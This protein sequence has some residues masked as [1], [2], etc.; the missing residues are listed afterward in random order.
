MDRTLKLLKDVTDAPGVPGYESEVRKVIR[1]Y[2]DGYAEI[3]YDR[4]G[5]II[6]KKTGTSDRPRIMIAGHMDEI[7]FMVTKITKE[8][9]IKFQTLGG[10][11][12]Q[13]MLAQ[14][15][16]IKTNKGD[17]PGIIGSKPP[18]ILSPEERNKVVDRDTMF[19][20]VGAADEK[21]ATEVFGIRPG[22]PIIP[23]S[24]FTIMKNEKYLMAKA[25]D[26]RL[27]CALFIEVI[28]A[29]QGVDHPNTVYGV[30]TVQ[31]EVGLRGAT[32][33]SHVIDPDIG[34]ALEV[35]I[36]GDTPGAE[37]ANE[38]LGQG[39][40]VLLYDA[41]M[42]PHVKLRDFVVDTA[43]QAGIPLQ[44]DHMAGGGT[45]AGRIH[46]N[47]RGVPSLCIAVPT[48]YI[49]SH[50]GIIHRDDYENAVKLV[51][52]L[53]KRLDEKTVNELNID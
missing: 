24:P 9:F 46:I 25:W 34:F 3:S 33:S 41:S 19:I 31:E 1:S 21:E 36:A 37:K 43:K 12:N 39:P 17:V 23:D 2:M 45:D 30:G 5:S 47:G 51:L 4:I 16:I 38:K 40:V 15:V 10:W 22:D 26:D 32:T 42:I 14:R 13:V 20:D 28:K 35:G 48:R 8:G 6:C 52:E 27:G 7:G 18:H 44:F 53:V 50:A 49:H 11:W 29:L